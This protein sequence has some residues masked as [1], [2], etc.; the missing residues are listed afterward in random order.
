MNFL[1]K[2]FG[3]KSND[4]RNQTTNTDIVEKSNTTTTEE[5]KLN[6]HGL[7]D[8]KQSVNLCCDQSYLFI[9]SVR[10]TCRKCQ[11]E[12]SIP[13]KVIAQSC[14]RGLNFIFDCC[15][16]NIFIPPGVYCDRC[17]V[18][19]IEGWEDL[20]DWS[21]AGVEAKESNV[22][23]AERIF[24]ERAASQEA[25]SKQIAGSVWAKDGKSLCGWNLAKPEQALNAGADPNGPG[26]DGC[27]FSYPL[28]CLISE[29]GFGYIS[30]RD[31]LPIM[32]L[33]IKH[34]ADPSLKI[35][36][37]E[38]ISVQKCFENFTQELPESS[39]LR[40]MHSLLQNSEANSARG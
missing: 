13:Q 35:N 14:K 1:K 19:L 30:P 20:I 8:G 24:E 33:L 16:Y 11:L 7:K 3:R 2:I 22:A 21:P 40:K 15:N 32:E 25:R 34:G 9:G 38:G 18:G 12:S 4:D 5:D 10:I 36:G 29:V 37:G 31:A 26:P 23:R 17:S 27:T 28:N 6:G 39:E